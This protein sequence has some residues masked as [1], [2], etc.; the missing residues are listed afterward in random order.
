MVTPMVTFDAGA[1]KVEGT[2]TG[3]QMVDLP[4]PDVLEA[5]PK[6]LA[7][8]A[9]DYDMTRRGEIPKLYE[10]FFALAGGL[11]TVVTPV[12]YGVSMNAQPDGSFRYGVGR[13]IDDADA[14]QPEG[15][16]HIALVGGPYL[17]WALRTPMTLMPAYFD[18]VF[19]DFLPTSDWQP[20]EGAVFELY[21]E[22]TNPVDGTMSY[23][24]W[25]PVEPRQM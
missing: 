13:E 14:P 17:R 10:R 16:C 1:G 6:L 20:R 21:P 4:N 25:V 12:L 18:A 7:G 9:D 2:E 3:A 23:E 8:V 22:D 19:S 5:P 11:Q 15:T 24:I